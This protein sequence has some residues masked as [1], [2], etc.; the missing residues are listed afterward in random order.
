MSEKFIPQRQKIMVAIIVALVMVFII[1]GVGVIK[2]YQIASLIK[3]YKAMPVPAETVTSLVVQPQSWESTLQAVGSLSAA[4]G[5]M[6]SADSPGV[7]SKIFLTSGT[8]VKKGDLLVQLETQ[9]EEA[10][11]CSAEAKLSLA[12]INL[13]RTNELSAKNVIA[14]SAFDDAEA[15][16]KG[17]LAAVNE[18]KATINKKT[19]RAPFDGMLGICQVNEGQYLNSGTPIV[20]LNLLDVINV[21]FSLPQHNFSDLSVGQVIKIQT[22]GIPNESFQGKITAINSELD[23]T[24]RNVKILGEIK[25]DKML[26]RGGMFVT[27]D[28]LLPTRTNVLIVPLSA[29]SYAPYGNTVFVIEKTNNPQGTAFLK[30]REQPVTLGA[31]RGDQVEILTGLKGGEEVIT[32]GIFK[33]HTGSSVKVNNSVQPS[34]NPTPQLSDS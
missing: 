13:Q 4:Q 18:I 16:Y 14:K 26:L 8:M 11:L 9:Q 6:L 3:V 22:D 20:P 29:I 31:T 10:Q 2:M 34:N 7:V 5:V 1:V 24:T 32:S 17:T 23:P 15:Q 33:L 12:K 25:N 28:V 30:V 19:L 21:N 27:V